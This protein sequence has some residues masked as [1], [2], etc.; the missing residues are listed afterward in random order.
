MD[1]RLIVLSSRG[2]TA[3]VEEWNCASDM[4]AAERAS[5]YVAPYGCELWRDDRR[6]G[7]YPGRMREPS[8]ARPPQ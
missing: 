3:E 5:A 4:A 6:I 8:Q 7:S 1:Y 2:E